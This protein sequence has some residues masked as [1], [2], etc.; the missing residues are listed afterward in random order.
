[1]IQFP[2]CDPRIVHAPGECQYCDESGLQAVREAWGMAFTGHQEA[3]KI[4]CPGETA[5]GME[6]LNKWGGNRARPTVGSVAE[7]VKSYLRA[8]AAVQLMGLLKDLSE[9]LFA[10]GWL[11]DWEYTAW[12]DTHDKPRDPNHRLDPAVRARLLELSELAEGWVAMLDPALIGPQF[13]PMEQWLTHLQAREQASVRA[14][15]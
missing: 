2:H 11:F 14:H 15:K 6:S 1:M 5:R 13:I 4:P 9:E 10:A 7:H 3:G 8:D 12:D